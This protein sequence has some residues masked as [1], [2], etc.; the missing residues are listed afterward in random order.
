MYFDYVF[1]WQIVGLIFLAC[2]FLSG[3]LATGFIMKDVLVA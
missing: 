1:R 3:I 2:G